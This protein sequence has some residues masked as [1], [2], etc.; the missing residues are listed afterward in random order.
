MGVLAVRRVHTSDCLRKRR[1]WQLRWPE[2]IGLR[3]GLKGREVNMDIG[4]E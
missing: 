4:R 2:V 3:A 1:D